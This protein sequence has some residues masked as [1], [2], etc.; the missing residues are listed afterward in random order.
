MGEVRFLKGKNPVEVLVKSRLNW[1]VWDMVEEKWFT[2]SKR[3]CWRKE[4]VTVRSKQK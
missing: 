3:N 2:T 1:L 4:K